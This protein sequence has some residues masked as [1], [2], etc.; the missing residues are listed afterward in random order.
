VIFDSEKEKIQ[1]LKLLT[2]SYLF[3]DIFNFGTIKKPDLL[4]KLLKALALQIGN[5]VSY[6]ELAGLV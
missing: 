4:I 5:Q 6:T 1:N 3:K 2:D